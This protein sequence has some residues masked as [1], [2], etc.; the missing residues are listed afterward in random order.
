[1]NN[2][3]KENSPQEPKNDTLRLKEDQQVSLA[4]S[5]PET[6]LQLFRFF[7]FFHSG[8][9]YRNAY[10]KAGLVLMETHRPIGKHTDGIPWRSELEFSPYKIHVLYSN[11]PPELA[12]A[13]T[14]PLNT[15]I[16]S[17]L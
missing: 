17:R 16:T 13:P 12:P 10:T 15:S 5:D 6:G 9:A 4:V 7:D 3:F 8:R 11:R 14:K 2:K 1:M